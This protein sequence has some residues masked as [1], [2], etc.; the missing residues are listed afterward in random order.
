MKLARCFAL[1]LTMLSAFAGGHFLF[2]QGTDL[3]TI[4]GLVTDSSGAVVPNAKVTVLD[5]AT[6]TPRETTTNAQGEYRVFG[7]SSGAYKVSV[8]APGMRT[9]QITG[10]ALNGSDT[11]NADAVLKVASTNEAVDVLSEAPLVNTEDQTISDT[12]T[13]RSVID[14]PRDS[15]N[16]YSFLY[17]NP[18]I[19]QSGTDGSF[20]FLGAQSYGANFSLDGQ[21]SNGGIFGEPTSSQPSLEAVGDINVLSND[22]SAEYAGIANIRVTTKRGGSGYRRLDRRADPRL[23][24]DMVFR[25]L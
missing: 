3:G 2:A 15:R 12:I 20:K 14:L 8:S 22:F 1:F 23:E 16:V 18:N 9:V 21:R 13:S 5:L 19:T 11:V 6:N 17:L 10:I 7:L 24:K 25:G 4:R